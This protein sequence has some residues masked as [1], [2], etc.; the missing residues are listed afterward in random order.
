MANTFTQLLYHIVFSTKERRPLIRPVRAEDLWR[1]IWGI[2]KKLK[3]HL[4]RINGVEDHVHILTHIHPTVALAKYL[5]TVKNSSTSWIARE[6]VFPHWHGWQDGYA[7]FTHS[8]REKEPL[9]EYIKGQQ[10]HHATE[11]YVDELKRLLAE[12]GITF[13]EK[14]LL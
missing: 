7:A 5:Q 11:S 10:V 8:I 2:N 14:Y 12:A 4:Y 6:G 1:Y 13:D 3:S 9:T